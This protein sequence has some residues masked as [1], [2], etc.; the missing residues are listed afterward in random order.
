MSWAAAARIHRSL[1]FLI[2]ACVL[3]VLIIYVTIPFAMKINPVIAPMMIYFNLF[4]SPFIDLQHPGKFINHTVNLYLTPEEGVTV[5]VWHTV[6]ESRWMETRGKDQQ[7]YEATLS[8]G[9]P[10]IVYLHGN[11]GN[12]AESYR[13]ALVKVLSANGFHVLAMDYRGWGDSTGYPSE[14]GLTMDSVHLYEWAR[15]R[16]GRS[17]VCLW[18]HSLG[19]G[20]ASNTARRL[21]EKGR[22]ADAIV[23]EAPFTTIREE[24]TCHP[25]SVIY[26]QFP[27]FEWFFLDPVTE[28]NIVFHNIENLKSVSSP[29]LILHAEDDPI[30]PFELGRKLYRSLHDSRIFKEQVKFVAFP[31][32][33]GYKHNLIYR[34]PRLPE[35]LKEFFKS[36][37]KC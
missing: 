2:K 15:A 5:G 31:G 36:T 3:T 26:K 17:F 21:Q 1:I 22:P 12:R 18:G 28:N 6:P 29:V 19:T 27:G 10:V 32:I 20:V 11:G 4:R 25:F 13:V 8:D 24:V 9:N 7:W 33:L 16:S 35:I 14:E 30:I 23:L 34:D 37:T